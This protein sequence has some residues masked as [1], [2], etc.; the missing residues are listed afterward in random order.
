MFFHNGRVPTLK[1]ALRFYVQRDTNSAWWYPKDAR[2]KVDKHND[3]PVI[4]SSDEFWPFGGLFWGQ[5]YNAQIPFL[6]RPPL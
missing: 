3:P 5:S 4:F 2:A 6:P 1:D